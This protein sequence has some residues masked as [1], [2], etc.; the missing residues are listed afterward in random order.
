MFKK[1]ILIMGCLLLVI[2]LCACNGHKSVSYTY[3]IDTGDAVK[4]TLDTT[5]SDYSIKPDGSNF[6]IY[7]GDELIIAQGYFIGAYSFGDYLAIITQNENVEIVE[8]TDKK[9]VYK[10]QDD[11]DAEYDMIECISD[12]TGV[13]V[14]SS[15]SGEVTNEMAKDILSRL[16]FTITDTLE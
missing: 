3:V 10:Y 9:I 11:K 15:I 13:V 16:T 7:Y 8:Q 14:G 4:V 5:N 2:S 6:V 1:I 12:L